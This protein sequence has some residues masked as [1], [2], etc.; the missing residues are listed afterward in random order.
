ME[1]SIAAA[2]DPDAYL[3]Y[4][5]VLTVSRNFTYIFILLQFL[6]SSADEEKCFNLAAS[7]KIMR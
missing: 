4:Y 2:T 5:D 6:L 1:S 3:Y 7:K